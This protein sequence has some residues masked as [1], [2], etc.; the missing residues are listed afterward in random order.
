MGGTLGRPRTRSGLGVDVVW[1]APLALVVLL[2]GTLALR[3][4][5]AAQPAG[6]VSA[7]VTSAAPQ[8]GARATASSWAADATWFQHLIYLYASG[9]P[10]I[11]SEARAAGVEAGLTPAQVGTVGRDVRA[12]WLALMRTDPASLGKP[13]ATP[14]VAEQ[15]TALGGLR[16]A[17]RT[18]AGDHYGAF[19]AA[20]ERVYREASRPDWLRAH[21]LV[22]GDTMAS[23]SPSGA[24]HVLAA[25]ALSPDV[26][27]VFATS[28]SLGWAETLSNG[29]VIAPTDA[30]VA[31]PDAYLKYANLGF[32]S[33]I[34]ALYRP[35]Y[36]SA[37]TATPLY[38]V[39]IATSA[40]RTVATG[41]P[42]ADVGPWNEDDNWW[43]PTNT[44]TTLPAGCPVASTLVSGASLANAAVDGICPGATLW[45]R[46]YY[47]LLYQ[48]V[49]LPF[50]QPAAYLPTGTFADA[51]AWPPV[52]PLACPESSA[53]SIN[54]D[55]VLCTFGLS[56]YNGNSGAWLRDGTYNAPVLNQ[57]AID[58]G[59]GVDAALGWTYPSSGFVQVDVSRLPGSQPVPVGTPH[60]Q[61]TPASLSLTYTPGIA[62][63]PQTLT[64]SNSG[65][66]PSH[67]S[68][69]SLPS[70]LALSAT[71]GMLAPGT[72]QTLTVSFQPGTAPVTCTAQLS[73]SDPAAD[74]SPVTVP[75]TLTPAQTARVWKWTF[76]RAGG[77]TANVLLAN[78]N[79]VPAVV[80]VAV[81]SGHFFQH[82]GYLLRPYATITV[83]MPL[84]TAPQVLI[85]VR[86]SRPVAATLHPPGR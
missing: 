11:Q 54:D 36:L 71:A 63:A 37:G 58:L 35:Y 7:P 39:D 77:Q 49:A 23:T 38:T 78:P 1:A 46:V 73:F 29:Q 52:L 60:L 22:S 85:V 18:L 31:L 59:P 25:P 47:Y 68:V 45:R 41:V 69:G 17:L 14:H 42:V 5:A 80:W 67:W 3:G 65:G 15:R 81:V 75:V 20:T 27:S 28:F 2:A 57:A 34:P 21:G 9:N 61:V 72:T 33:S 13:H 43:D 8:A 74:D 56:G 48:H 10:V 53:A 55:G 64:L 82:H 16:A 66:A 26:V 30:Y 76:D 40:G 6:A 62:P 24:G 4:P 70:W 51:N 86:A 12:V 83:P 44:S 32:G 50:F 84:G 79:A 19:L